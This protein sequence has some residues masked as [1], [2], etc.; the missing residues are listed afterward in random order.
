MEVSQTAKVDNNGAE[1]CSVLIFFSFNQS[2]LTVIYFI[3]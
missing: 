2:N 1:S 3:Y